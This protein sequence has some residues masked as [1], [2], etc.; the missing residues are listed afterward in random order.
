MPAMSVTAWFLVELMRPLYDCFR[1]P[2][3]DTPAFLR[4]DL[5]GFLPTFDIE[6]PIP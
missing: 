1:Q 6:L 3:P 5:T 4:G 2:I